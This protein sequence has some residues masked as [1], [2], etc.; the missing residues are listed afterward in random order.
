MDFLGIANQTWLVL[1]FALFGLFFGAYL[2]SRAK[3]EDAEHA[4]KTLLFVWLILPLFPVMLLFSFF[5]NSAEGTV[6][7]VQFGGSI[8][9][10]VALFYFGWSQSKD[11]VTT[12]ELKSQLNNATNQLAQAT[13]KKPDPRLATVD[14]HEYKVKGTHRYVSL[15]TGDIRNIRNEGLDIWVNTENTQMQMARFYDKNISGTMRYLGAKKDDFNEVTEDIIAEEL[16]AQIGDRSTVPPGTVV[17]TGAGDLTRTHG[18]KNIFH[19]ASV[20]GEIGK[21]YQSIDQLG[22]CVVNA[23]QKAE[24][25]AAEPDAVPLETMMIPVLGSG[26]G[27]ASF[28]DG[29]REQIEHAIMFFENN[30]DSQIKRV[31]FLASRQSKLEKLQKIIEASDKL[32]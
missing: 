21:G 13:G 20:R 4:N 5:D 23:L 10:Y 22:Q 27:G 24:D 28:E 16:A 6:L 26:E 32:S 25:M 18:V 2:F 8:A 11:A 31:Y 30:H 14:K 15:V 3:K 12:D 1:G 17:V 29:A 19:V 9:A 7:G